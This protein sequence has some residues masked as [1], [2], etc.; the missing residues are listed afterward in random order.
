MT[1]R[2][3]RKFYSST[4]LPSLP[5]K[6]LSS[7]MRRKIAAYDIESLARSSAHQIC[8]E[9]DFGETHIG[10]GCM[11]DSLNIDAVESFVEDESGEYPSEIYSMTAYQPTDYEFVRIVCD[12]LLSPIPLFHHLLQKL[13]FYVSGDEMSINLASPYDDPSKE[14]NIP[15]IELGRYLWY[16]PFAGILKHMAEWLRYEKD[17]RRAFILAH[18]SAVVDNDRLNTDDLMIIPGYLFHHTSPDEYYGLPEWSPGVITMNND[19]LG[20]N[21]ITASLLGWNNNM[22]CP[23]GNAVNVVF[24]K[25]SGMNKKEQLKFLKSG[26]Q[27]GWHTNYGNIKF[28]DI[29]K[30]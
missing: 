15:Q 9:H 16:K 11:W 7:Y 12:R 4:S 19:A 24:E 22:A 2:K 26:V 29:W 20:D 21:F 1:N 5:V 8:V 17:Y 27:E 10:I 3:K 28:L 14:D 30:S 23:S 13:S 18:V 25:M 6:P